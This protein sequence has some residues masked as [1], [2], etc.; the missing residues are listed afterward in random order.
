[1]QYAG[2]VREPTIEVLYGTRGT[3]PVRWEA[4]KSSLGCGRIYSIV[5]MF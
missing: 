3:E 2:T 1:M 5:A 4:K